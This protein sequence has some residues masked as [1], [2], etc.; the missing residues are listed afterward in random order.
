MYVVKASDRI[1][2]SHWS[3][4][5]QRMFRSIL[6]HP[7][8]HSIVPIFQFPCVQTFWWNV[9]AGLLLFFSPQKW[10]I[11]IYCEHT[12]YWTIVKFRIL[13]ENS[14]YN[15]INADFFF[16]LYQQIAIK[17]LE[18]YRPDLESINTWLHYLKVSSFRT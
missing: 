11:L 17:I 13:T 4:L 5:V 9:F 10:P 14:K 12:V 18:T 8:W 16:N 15:L 7:S 1:L 3:I 2:S 6:Q